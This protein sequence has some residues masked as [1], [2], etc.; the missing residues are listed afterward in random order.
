MER[1]GAMWDPQIIQQRPP[2]PPR[3][4][5]GSNGSVQLAATFANRCGKVGDILERFGPLL[6]L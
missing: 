6:S 3:P 4:V 1:L 2:T 5:H